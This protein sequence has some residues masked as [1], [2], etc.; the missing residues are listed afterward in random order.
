MDYLAEVRIKVKSNR[1][2]ERLYDE[3]LAEFYVY[4]YLH[5]RYFL[6]TKGETVA[7]LEVLAGSPAPKETVFDPERFAA[8]RLK[9]IRGLLDR[10]G[11]ERCRSSQSESISSGESSE[12]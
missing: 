10:F 12:L 5:G 11:E 2:Y 8:H 6:A 1:S 7:A 3:T 9:L 4:N